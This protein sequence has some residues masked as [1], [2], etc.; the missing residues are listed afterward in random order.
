[1][2]NLVGRRLS[3]Y[4]PAPGRYTSTTAM[5][6]AED[7]DAV[8]IATP[9]HLHFELAA[10]ALAQDCHVLIEKPMVT[11]VSD[12]RKL[13]NL[14]DSS[15]RLVSVCYNTAYSDATVFVR[16]TISSGEYGRLELVTGYLSQDWK[17]LTAGSWR[18]DVAQSGGGQAMDSGAH[19]F[20]TLLWTTQM[21][22]REVFACVDNLGTGVDINSSALVK[23]QDG[24]IASITVG[25]NSAAIGSHLSFVFEN[26][27]IE[28][29]GWEGQW[30]R[31]IGPDGRVKEESNLGEV[32]PDDNFVDAINGSAKPRCTVTDGLNLAVLMEAF[33]KSA[34]TGQKTIPG[35]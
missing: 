1:M 29:D 28:M 21:R 8:V 5:Y 11:T 26:G 12:A 15:G 3:E 14:A 7:V 30:Y 19:L 34:D 22:P 17:R 20:N 31:A 6:S 25:G 33:Y 24:L 32:S 27:R 2:E 23:F 4:A 10:E 18:Q 35:A 16:E 9:H 13:K